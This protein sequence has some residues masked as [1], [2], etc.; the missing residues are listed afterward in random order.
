MKNRLILLGLLAISFFSCNKEEEEDMLLPSQS[1][2]EAEFGFQKLDVD[3]L[4]NAIDSKALTI[5]GKTYFAGY[6]FDPIKSRD[7]FPVFNDPEFQVA[8]IENTGDFSTYDLQVATN[9]NE[10]LDYYRRVDCIGISYASAGT[11][12]GQPTEEQKCKEEQGGNPN[13]GGPQPP[14]AQASF[15]KNAAAAAPIFNFSIK[16]KKEVLKDLRIDNNSV[17]VIANIKN[18]QGGYTI[19][20]I[21]IKDPNSW[22]GRILGAATGDPDTYIPYF[23]QYYG[24]LFASTVTVGGEV[25][26]VYTLDTSNLTDIEKKELITNVNIGLGN[27][28]GFSTG[29][30][31]T[32]EQKEIIKSKTLS[33][34]V[35]SNVPGFVPGQ[36]TVDNA[37][38]DVIAIANAL[39]DYLKQNPNKAAVMNMVPGNYGASLD[40]YE[41]FNSVGIPAF[42]W[43]PAE[44]VTR[45]L[46]DAY[47]KEVKCYVDWEQWVELQSIMESIVNTSTDDTKKA[48]AKDALNTINSQVRNSELNCQNSV[49]PNRADYLHII[50]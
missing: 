20:G 38:Q 14:A 29:T 30:T 19:P 41:T 2:I 44:N 18:Y 24:P 15:T 50:I 21:Q 47:D 25:D 6:G 3:E 33:I 11:P 26:Y 23:I 16:R 36:I 42:P 34:K 32:V 12:T 43:A 49:T 37:E 28:F 35:S 22:A 46:K 27:I 39:S 40:L 1:G 17:V 7:F 10:V 9:Y 4:E 45:V 5:D 31:L 48:Q 13:P 8:K